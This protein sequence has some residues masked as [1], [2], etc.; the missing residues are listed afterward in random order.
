[1]IIITMI[2]LLIVIITK[3]MKMVIGIMLKIIMIIV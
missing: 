3:A 2:I 1:M